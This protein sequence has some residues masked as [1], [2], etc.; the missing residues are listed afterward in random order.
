MIKQ[1]LAGAVLVAGLAQAQSVTTSR[2]ILESPRTM[3]LEVKFSPFTPLMDRPFEGDTAATLPYK[4]I[5]GGGPLLLGEVQFDYQFFQRFG[6]LSGGI[7]VGYGEKFGKSLAADTGATIE[8]STGL[9][10][11]PLKAVL[12]YRFD[13]AK[14]RWAV[15][16]VPYLKGA[17]VAMPWW[18]TNGGEIEVS[19]GE[20]AE[21]IKYGVAGVLG[22][23]LELDFLDQRL[24][25]DFDTGLGVNHSYLFAEYT[26]QDM[27]LF[28]T[29]ALALD[30]SSY[31]W[32]FG[33]AF[34]L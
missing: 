33:L 24:A 29:S 26:V 12:S 4:Q 5:L 16:L 27:R 15:P 20:R 19:A 9:R 13:W 8:Q 23:L 21:G 6:S 2:T 22:L 1:M 11:L 31:H 18:M 34:E 32:M 7:S 3:F 10:L 14:Q 30:F 28:N 17:F 25:R